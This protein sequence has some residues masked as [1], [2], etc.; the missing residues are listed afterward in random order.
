MSCLFRYHHE[1]WK[2]VHNPVDYKTKV[3]KTPPPHN[4]TIHKGDVHAVL[5]RE[6]VKYATTNK[7]ALDFMDWL[8]DAFCPEEL[9]YSSLQYNPQ[10]KAPGAYKGIVQLFLKMFSGP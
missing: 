7:M 9:F 5:S 1:R 8:K 2:Y 10:L 3:R 4:I 6:F